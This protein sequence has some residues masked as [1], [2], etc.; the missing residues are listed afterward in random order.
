MSVDLTDFANYFYTNS[1]RD[2]SIITS[3]PGGR[4][5]YTFFV[6][7][8]GGKLGGWVVLDKVFLYN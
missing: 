7:L 6:I 5:V 3:P 4:W 8:R 1:S 2:D